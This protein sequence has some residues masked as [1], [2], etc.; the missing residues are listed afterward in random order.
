MMEKRIGDFEGAN[1]QTV[2]TTA[3]NNRFEVGY[4]WKERDEPHFQ[5]T[6]GMTTNKLKTLYDNGKTQDGYI[7]IP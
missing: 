7:I 6:E 2:I 1:W 4:R 3:E 5:N